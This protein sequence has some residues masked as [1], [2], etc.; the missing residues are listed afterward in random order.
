MTSIILNFSLVMNF[1]VGDTRFDFPNECE[2]KP[3]ETIDLK[4]VA[5]RPY[6]KGTYTAW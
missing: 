5:S 2:V 3:E 1:S 6:T 4:I